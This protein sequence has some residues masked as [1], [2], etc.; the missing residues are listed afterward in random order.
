MV[1]AQPPAPASRKRRPAR[2]LPQ[3]ERAVIEG[4][5]LQGQTAAVV[6]A[7]L[8]CSVA[9]VYQVRDKAL[10]KLR[11]RIESRGDLVAA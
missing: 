7:G 5:V 10:Q 11:R 9:Y 8:G 6:G 4:V 2:R 3:I 1:D